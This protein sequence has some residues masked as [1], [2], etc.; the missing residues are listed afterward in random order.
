MNSMAYFL[1]LPRRR[2]SIKNYK[3]LDTRFRGYDNTNQLFCAELRKYKFFK[4]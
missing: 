2:E 4:R 1:S 3:R